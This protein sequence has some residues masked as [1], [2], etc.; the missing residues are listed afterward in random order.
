[1]AHKLGGDM[2]HDETAP[3]MASKYFKT[4]KSHLKAGDMQ[5]AMTTLRTLMADAESAK[6]RKRP[7]VQLYAT[8][9]M[10]EFHKEIARME[11]DTEKK[12]ELNTVN[13]Y[14][15]N[16]TELNTFDPIQLSHRLNLQLSKSVKG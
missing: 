12:P 6:G 1:M 11:I 8:K 10:I 5:L 9:A 2:Q 14:N 16:Q 3:D 13:I 15:L 7:M 4:L